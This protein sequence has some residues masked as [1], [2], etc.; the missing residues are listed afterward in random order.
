MVDRLRIEPR[1][2]EEVEE[3][4][5]IDRAG[6][7]RHRHAFERREAH[8]RVNGTAVPNRGHRAP[9][10]EVADDQPGGG[11]ALCGPLNRE[12]MEA[13]TADP[14]FLAPAPRDRIRGRRGRNGGVE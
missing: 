4:A 2:A 8:R 7:S 9:T 6:A 11:H 13:V 1:L 10:A 14:P 5:G 3:R 12:T